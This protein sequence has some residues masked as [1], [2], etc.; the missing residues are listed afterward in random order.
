MEDESEGFTEL[1][2][3]VAICGCE[4][5]GSCLYDQ[6]LNEVE[7]YAVRLNCVKPILD[8]DEE[9]HNY[10]LCL[11]QQQTIIEILF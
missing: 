6:I 10:K 2:I 4:N 9:S 1:T 8:N 11:L 5:N 7:N 3:S